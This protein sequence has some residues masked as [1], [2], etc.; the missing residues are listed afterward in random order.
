MSNNNIRKGRK[1]TG[2]SMKVYLNTR[3]GT[4]KKATTKDASTVVCLVNRVA[5]SLIELE[6]MK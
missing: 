6:E 5:K 2:L 4:L 1:N 3:L